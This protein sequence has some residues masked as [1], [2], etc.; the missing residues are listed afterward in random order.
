MPDDQQFLYTIRPIRIEMLTEGP[1]D[2]E[3]EIITQ[4]F[5][6]LS[7][8]AAQGVVEFAGRTDTDD[9][10]TFG[11]VVFQARS[12]NDALKIVQSDP[13]VAEGVMVPELFPFRLAVCASH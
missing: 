4:H 2:R 10:R 9:E 11:I 1:T 6:Y 7:E 8:L 13:A 3:T 5:D 12:E